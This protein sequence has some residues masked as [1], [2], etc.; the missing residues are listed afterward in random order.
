[1]VNKIQEGHVICN[2][3]RPDLI[4]RII[5]QTKIILMCLMLMWWICNKIHSF[6]SFSGVTF[7]VQARWLLVNPQ[8]GDFK[9]CWWP[10]L[11][12]MSF[13]FMIINAQNVPGFLPQRK[14][15]VKSK[16][17]WL[18]FPQARSIKRAQLSVLRR[19]LFSALDSNCQAHFKATG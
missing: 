4:W 6:V 3:Q 16:F 11:F 8:W 14:S 12:P 10:C 9:W 2:Y 1:M 13:I 19:W 5:T 18:R 15:S 17:H 7:V